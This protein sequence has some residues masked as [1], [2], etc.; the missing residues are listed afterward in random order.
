M[1]KTLPRN[2]RAV[3]LPNGPIITNGKASMKEVAADRWRVRRVPYEAPAFRQAAEPFIA[4]PAPGR[5]IPFG[6]LGS[7]PRRSRRL[8]NPAPN[9][10]RLLAISKRWRTP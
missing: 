5:G 9:S 10:M 8:T 7:L 6:L 3:H 4:A 1:S 2:G